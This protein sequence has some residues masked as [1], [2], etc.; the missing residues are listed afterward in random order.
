MEKLIVFAQEVNMNDW[1]AHGGD[2]IPLGVGLFV[3]LVVLTIVLFIIVGA[4]LFRLVPLWLICKKA[5][6]NPLLSLLI[7]VPLVN[8]FLMWIIALIDWPN[9]KKENTP[10]NGSSS[11]PMQ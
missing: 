1:A 7:F 2:A 8:T 9:V 5:G 3:V 6:L 4:I 11:P 10:T